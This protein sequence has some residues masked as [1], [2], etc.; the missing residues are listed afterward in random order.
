MLGVRELQQRATRDLAQVG[1]LA[2]E[3]DPQALPRPAD[4]E[5]VAND[6]AHAL[7]AVV[8]AGEGRG[9][10]GREPA[11][12]QQEPRPQPDRREGGAQ[13]V[14][15]GG[16]ELLLEPAD[17]LR[18]ATRLLL[19]LEEPRSVEGLRA[20]LRQGLDEGALGGREAAA[21]RERERDHAGTVSA[22]HQRH[23]RAA[24]FSAPRPE[25]LQ[26]RVLRPDLVGA[27]EP[28]GASPDERVADREA[29]PRARRRVEEA[30]LRL[31]HAAAEHELQLAG[32]HHPDDP[33]R[34]R[35]ELLEALLEQDPGHVLHRRRGRERGGEVLEPGDAGG[36][37]LGL[38]LQLLGAGAR[39]ALGVVDLGARDRE[40]ALAADVPGEA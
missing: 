26:R 22:H 38:A 29:L 1:R 8:D 12:L 25:R 35:P 4:V 13:V 17:A 23:D 9:L 24:G 30:E 16:H 18:L 5:Q 14:A 21:L 11:V 31:A 33:Q 36:R 27:L 39:D 2:P 19:R 3:G 10:G 7:G 32:A 34:L 20:Q 40:A 37:E 6:R 28:D 15:H